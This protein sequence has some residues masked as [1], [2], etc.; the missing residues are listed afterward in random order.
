MQFGS[1]YCYFDYVRSRYG[2]HWLLPGRGM[3]ETSSIPEKL[4]LAYQELFEF[5]EATVKK[6][7]KFLS[8]ERPD[9][10]GKRI[11]LIHFARAVYLL[12]AM[13]RLCNQGFATE[14]QVLLRSLLNLYIN[15]KWLTTGNTLERMERYADFGFVYEILAL[16]RLVARR[17]LQANYHP[18]PEFERVKEKY[19][20]KK[21]R[22][23]FYWSGKTIKQMAIEVNL[24]GEYEVVYSRLSAIEHT[25]PVSAASYVEHREGKILIKAGPREDNI[26][27]A[28]LTGLNYYFFVEGVTRETFGIDCSPLEQDSREWARLS[29]KYL[30]GVEVKI[31]D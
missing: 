29:I 10:L 11:T 14:A 31:I 7:R 6:S 20:L 12:E 26:R 21:E 3:S 4:K 16:D 15:I 25:G 30:S 27:L 24:V 18:H 2:Y 19:K 1:F 13:S 17:G 22:D 9:T 5:T 28:L 23:F 8:G